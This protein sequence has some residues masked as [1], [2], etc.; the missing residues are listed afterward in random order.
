MVQHLQK[1]LSGKIKARTESVRA[2]PQDTV[3]AKCAR[4]YR[5]DHTSDGTAQVR[6]EAVLLYCLLI[7]PQYSRV[8]KYY[9]GFFVKSDSGV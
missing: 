4:A 3:H 8:V 1:I 9:F 6:T 5:I 2:D 7:L